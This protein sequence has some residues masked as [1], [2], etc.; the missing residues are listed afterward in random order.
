VDKKRLD[1][2]WKGW[3]RENLDRQCDPE[4]LLSVLIGNE[5]SI[6]SIRENMG[7][8]FP[9]SSVY[10]SAVGYVRAASPTHD[11]VANPP[12]LRG[13]LAARLCRLGGSR[14]QLYVLD[15]FLPGPECDAVAEI[16]NRSLRPSTVT[17]DSGDRYFRTSSTSDLSVLGS[18]V[19]A[20]LDEKIARTLGVRTAYSEGIQGQRYEVSQEFKPHTDFFEPGTD[21]YRQH[22]SAAGNRTWT[23]MVYLNDGIEGGG[24]RFPLIGYTVE[25]RK[26]RAVIWNN[27]QADGS[28]NRDTLHAGLPVTRGHKVI[29]TKWF[30]EKGSGPLLYSQG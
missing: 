23:F 4:E 11:A 30:R 19:V 25:P 1:D 18:S 27:L 12:L 24:T 6:E 29:I 20:A 13:P 22:A 28:P 21:E 7:D 14:V 26:G 10:L 5:F 9:A 2:S 3:L 15:D 17:L 16:V 8:K